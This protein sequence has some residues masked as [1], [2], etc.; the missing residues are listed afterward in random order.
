MKPYDYVWFCLKTG[1]VLYKEDYFSQGHSLDGYTAPH[2]TAMEYVPL[3][4]RG[5]SFGEWEHNNNRVILSLDYKVSTPP[6]SQ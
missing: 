5:T 4:F 2:I 6:V 3:R 1:M